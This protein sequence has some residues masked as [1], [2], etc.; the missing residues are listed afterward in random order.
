M[1]TLLRD[2]YAER[3]Q[4][5][6][7]QLDKAFAELRDMQAENKRLTTENQS[8]QRSISKLETALQEAKQDLKVH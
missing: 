4:A 3:Q 8:Q 5:L 2:A 7:T 6:Q 1:V